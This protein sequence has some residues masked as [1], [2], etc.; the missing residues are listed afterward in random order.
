GPFAPDGA[1][2]AVVL[3]S[4]SGA[5]TRLQPIGST[6]VS[7]PVASNLA[8]PSA[9]TNR[10]GPKCQQAACEPC[11]RC[12]FSS[13][14]HWSQA[15]FRSPGARLVTAPQPPSMSGVSSPQAA[16]DAGCATHWTGAAARHGPPLASD[17]PRWHRLL[18][19]S[20]PGRLGQ[21]LSGCSSVIS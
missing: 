17:G 9:T 6:S 5:A 19:G 10:P 16:R 11:P 14:T 20:G 18:S 2:G 4:T 1:C 8:I 12:L 15:T 13:V 21:S 7:S 3:A